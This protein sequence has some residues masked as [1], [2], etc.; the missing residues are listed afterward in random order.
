M[1]TL[2][3]T[4]LLEQLKTSADNMQKIRKRKETERASESQ[5][6]SEPRTPAQV[7]LTTR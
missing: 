4:E 2:G 1:T 6:E 5:Q 7:D 3:K